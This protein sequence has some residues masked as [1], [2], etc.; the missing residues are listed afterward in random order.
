MKGKLGLLSRS[1]FTVGLLAESVRNNSN[2]KHV[3][4]KLGDKGL[5]SL[6]SDNVKQ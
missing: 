2:A 4:L 3:F 1:R 6:S 5:I